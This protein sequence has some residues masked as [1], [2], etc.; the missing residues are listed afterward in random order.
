MVIAGLEHGECVLEEDCPY[1]DAEAAA[2]F[3]A[4]Y[5]AAMQADEERRR[6][7]SD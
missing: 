6:S 7:K 1:Y 5:E 2:I 4:G 3:W